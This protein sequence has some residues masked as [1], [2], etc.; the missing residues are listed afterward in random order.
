MY[1]RVI[2]CTETWDFPDSST[3]LSTRQTEQLAD[4]HNAHELVRFLKQL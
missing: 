2:S 1:L 3:R 4:L